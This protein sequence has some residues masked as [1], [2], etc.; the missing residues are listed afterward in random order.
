[1][2]IARKLKVEF[3][4]DLP[5]CIVKD[6]PFL[7]A[8]LITMSFYLP[9]GEKY[10][11]SSLGG[12]IKH[13]D[14]DKDSELIKEIKVFIHQ[15]SFHKDLHDSM[16]AVFER[17]TKNKIGEWI[18]KKIEEH[19]DDYIKGRVGLTM[20]SEHTTCLLTNWLINN[21]HQ[22]QSADERIYKVTIWHCA[23]EIEHRATAFKVSPTEP[24]I[25]CATQM[26]LLF[27]LY[28]TGFIA[29]KQL[30]HGVYTDYK[31]FSISRFFRIFPP[32]WLM[33]GLS[34]LLMP[35]SMLYLREGGNVFSDIASLDLGDKIFYYASHVFLLINLLFYVSYDKATHSLDSL[36]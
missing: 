5:S 10:I 3:G 12:A 7:S 21:R 29:G 33:L 25:H 14:K 17:K 22:F 1:M 13:L 34:F 11:M 15:E 27:A 8:F 16:N 23:E 24:Y 19:K 20:A 9:V 31:R 18:N 6:N 30:Y 28:E 4:D 35:N 32:C 2:L 36:S 26:L